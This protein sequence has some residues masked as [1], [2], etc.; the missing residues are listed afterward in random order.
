MFSA[1]SG[2]LGVGM[3]HSARNMMFD[4]YAYNSLIAVVVGG[5]SFAGGIGTYTGTI[6]GSAV[7][8]MLSNM[9]TALNL[10]QRIRE[11]TLGLVLVVLLVMYNRKKAVRQ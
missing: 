7:M 5:T 9:L 6:A 3:L 1:F 2:M 8:V 4:A 10:P 11:I